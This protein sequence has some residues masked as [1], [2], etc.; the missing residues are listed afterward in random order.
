MMRPNAV[1]KNDIFYSFRSNM[2]GV[3]FLRFSSFPLKLYSYNKVLVYFTKGMRPKL[4]QDSGK[5]ELNGQSFH[6]NKFFL[7]LFYFHL[8]TNIFQIQKP[9]LE[10]I[11]FQNSNQWNLNWVLLLNGTKFWFPYIRFEFLYLFSN[12]EYAYY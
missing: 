3:N 11:Q 5:S 2:S 4:W 1:K 9:L 12:M 10:F 8:G 7:V 6:N